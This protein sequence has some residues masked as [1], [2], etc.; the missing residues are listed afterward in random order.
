MDVTWY[1]MYVGSVLFAI[2]GLITNHHYYNF[3]CQVSDKLKLWEATV[4]NS[5]N[6]Y[7]R[8]CNSKE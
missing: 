2:I 7:G 8:K 1:S 6:S 3:L 4:I 5:S